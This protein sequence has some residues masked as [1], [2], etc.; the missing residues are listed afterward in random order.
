MAEIIAGIEIP[1]TAAAGE[2]TD[3]IRATTTGPIFHHSRRVFLF[4][5]IHA[6]RLG[7]WPDPELL[8]LSALFHDTGLLPPYRGT[9]QRFEVD[10]ADTARLFLLE[11][12]YSAAAA[13]V[14]WT[15]VALHTTPGIPT[16][17]APEIAATAYGVLT[18]MIGWDL[19]TIG[20]DELT[21]I[22]TAHP[23]TDFKN[24]IIRVLVDGTV[25]ADVLEQHLP[26][27]HRTSLTGRILGSA[28][29]D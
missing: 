7:L 25:N 26:G 5:M 16:R 1:D 9:E 3:L 12:G 13:D 4:G 22:T 27:F 20:A 19:G 29:P 6:G 8:Y 11:R 15:A 2:A 18:D 24:E 21:G 23:R 10:G 17:M 28:W 14:V